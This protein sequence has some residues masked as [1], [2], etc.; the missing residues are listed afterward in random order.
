V[1]DLI[2]FWLGHAEQS[3]TDGY[4]KLGEDLEFRAQVAESV[5]TGFAVPNA[6]R[7]T[8]PRKSKKV[9]LEIAA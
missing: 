7:P 9:E 1:E 6:L 2:Q 8:V 3:V 5:R 4:S